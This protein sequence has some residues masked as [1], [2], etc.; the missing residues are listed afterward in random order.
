M[1]ITHQPDFRRWPRPLILFA[2]QKPSHI[3]RTRLVFSPWRGS[4]FVSW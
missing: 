4:M 3:P 1:G 2:G